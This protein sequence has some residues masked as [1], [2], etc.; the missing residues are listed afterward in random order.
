[1]FVCLEREEAVP[2]ANSASLEH[3]SRTWE[4]ENEEAEEVRKRLLVGWGC[5]FTQHQDV[6]SMLNAQSAAMYF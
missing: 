1:V 4:K 3:F 5:F 6:L 2:F